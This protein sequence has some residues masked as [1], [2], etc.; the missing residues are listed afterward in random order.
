[1]HEVK[2]VRA[3]THCLGYDTPINVNLIAQYGLC[4]FGGF[5]IMN[6]ESWTVHV[7]A[8]SAHI[9]CSR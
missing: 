8:P 3:H 9:L 2:L 4:G 6:L 5:Y 1:M 7:N